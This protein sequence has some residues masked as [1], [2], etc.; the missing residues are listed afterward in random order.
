MINTHTIKTAQSSNHTTAIINISLS[1]CLC[2]CVYTHIEIHREI[3]ICGGKKNK[4]YNI[5]TPNNGYLGSREDEERSEMRYV[6]WIA[7][8]SESSNLWTQVALSWFNP[9]GARS[10]E[11]RFHFF[12]SHHHH[13]LSR[14]RE[15]ERDEET[16][17]TAHM[18]ARHGLRL[19][20]CVCVCLSASQSV[21]HTTNI[22]YRHL[23]GVR[24]SPTHSVC[25]CAR[26]HGLCWVSPICVL[27]TMGIY[28]LLV[29][30]CVSRGCVCW[31]WGYMHAAGV[32]QQQ[33]R[34]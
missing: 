1:V 13:S 18:C 16:G 10:L 31:I 14:K 27:C 4:S 17:F 21:T 11:C 2:V 22:V 29:G 23:T 8:I 5:T 20:V 32:S 30:V 25:V 9:P 6:V 34:P 19:C 15:G 28:A 33:Q 3:F 24:G 12:Y 26:A 7:G